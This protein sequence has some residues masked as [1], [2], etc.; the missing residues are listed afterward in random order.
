[1]RS[2]V[3]YGFLAPPNVFIALCLLGAIVA[4]IWRRVGITVT[5]AASLCLFVTAT[6]A[7]AAC[8]L[9]WLEA[10]I[11][12]ETDFSSAEAI[13]VLGADVRPGV[14][15]APDRLGPQ[16][17]ERLIFATDAYKQLR[18]PV[19]VSGG[20][21]PRS[22]TSVAE[23]MKVTLEQYFAVPVTWSEVRSRTTYENALHTTQL[24]QKTNIRTVIVI[25]QARD[26]PR[27]IWSF[28][29]VGMRALPWP[30]PRS[31]LKTDRIV[32]FLPSTGALDESFYA[33]HELIGGLYY[34][35]RY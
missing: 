14:D 7:F 10:N 33:L 30:E 34:R 1:M 35:M 26:T 31:G 12:Q 29:R 24:L 23:M 11:Q 9:M 16:S 3:G 27:A 17:L 18:L 25:T 8:L 20:R 19:A 22:R 2:V 15:P 21:L 28:E 13:V 4:P 6:P 32:D 5:L